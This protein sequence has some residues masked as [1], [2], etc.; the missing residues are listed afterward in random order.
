MTVQQILD[1]VRGMLSCA[2]GFED[3]Q[4]VEMINTVQQQ[5]QVRVMGAQ[6]EDTT[7]YRYPED[8]GEQVLLCGGFEVIYEDY[9][10]Y[11]T[12]WINQE[13]EIA[14]NRLQAVSDD[15][16]TFENWYVNEKHPGGG[17]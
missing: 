13:W 12:A 9:I 8:L 11:R 7:A 14:A 3:R 10:L 17:I 15:F 16:D 1:R 5:L 2:D 4:L 6:P